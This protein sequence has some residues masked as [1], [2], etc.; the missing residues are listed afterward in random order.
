M[1]ISTPAFLLAKRVF[2]VDD[3]ANIAD[4]LSLILRRV[5]FTVH[6]FYDGQTALEHAQRETPDIVLSDIVMPKMDGLELASKLREQFPHCRILLVS[7]N[8]CYS[9]LLSKQESENSLE[10]AILA[11][12]VHPDIIIRKLTA[13]AVAADAT[14]SRPN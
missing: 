8:A 10:L 13:M 3:E 6:T 5:G 7:A 9:A 2:V 11:K 14:D 1:S 12:P 4:T